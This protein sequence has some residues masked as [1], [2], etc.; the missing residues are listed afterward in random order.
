MLL[1]LE[2]CD[3]GIA[4]TRWQRSRF[5]RA[6]QPLIQVLHDGIDTDYF[7]PLPGARLRLP[8]LDLGAAQEI[9]TYVAR[10]MDS[11]RGFPQLIEALGL[12]LPRRPGCHAVIV[13]ADRVAYGPPPPG[14][15]T[16]R[17]HML[18]KVPLDPSRVHFTGPLPLE[19]YRQVLQASSVHVYLTR[20]FVLSW[21]LLEAMASGC[22]VV[23]SDTAPVREA[24]EDGVNGLLTD[25]F[26]VQAL[27]ARIEEALEAGASLRHLRDAA[28]QTV[29]DRY[30]LARLLPLHLEFLGAPAVR[31]PPA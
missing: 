27:A 14:G 25:F 12:L 8:T 7:A 22:L 10:G 6:F 21:S 5:P 13:G 26:D 16:Y 29:L 9:V 11:Y 4:P 28:R 30:A 20:P 15:G 18:A 23:A 1:D 24:M 17:D 3:A 31:A 2:A 19:L